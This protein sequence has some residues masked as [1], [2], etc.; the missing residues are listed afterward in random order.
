MG[1][2][3]SWTMLRKAAVFQA[4]GG[5]CH[6]CGE[7]IDG[8]RERWDLEHIIAIA[9]GGADDESNVAPAHVDCHKPKTAED[10]RLMAKEARVKAKHIGAK[11]QPKRRLPGGKG[12]GW[13]AKVGGG[14]ERRE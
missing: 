14:W 6:L 13:R 10:R 2:R 11:P 4:H 7:K 3:R 5:I 8:T 9:R 1:R 12:S